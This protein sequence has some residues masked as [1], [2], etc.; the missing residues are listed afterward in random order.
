MQSV[1]VTRRVTAVVALLAP[2]A[3]VTLAVVM[4]VARPL[5]VAGAVLG[6]VVGLYSA[7]YALTRT[8]F[9]RA[10]AALLAVLALASPVA[11]ILVFGSVWDFI[12]ILGVGAAGAAAARH[13]LGRDI[14]S[15]KRGPTPGEPVGPAQRPVLLMNPRS[16]GGKVERF[17]LVEEARRRGIEPV[18]LGPG[19]DLAELA[20][21]AVANGADAIGM[22]G[23][24]GS[25][26]L[27]AEVAMRHGVG[28]VC[29]PAGTRNHL[30]MDLGLDRNDVVGALDA[31]GD[32]V[33]RRIDLAMS[34]D[35]VFVNNACM[36]L[37]AK[38]VQSPAYRQRKVATALEMLP[39]LLGTPSP[40]FDL[41][42]TGPD[43]R[44]HSSAHL[45]LVSN[46]RYELTRVEG[47]GSRRRI[48]AGV[49]GIVTATFRS[50]ADVALFIELQALGLARRFP[51]WME[52]TDTSFEVRS[53]KSV[54]IGVDGDPISQE[55]AIPFRIV[56]KALRVRI[57]HHAP[58]YSPAAAVPTRGWSTFVALWQTA[59]GR[60]VSVD[61]RD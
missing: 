20:R 6:L 51:G 37:Y 35:A 58:G 8:G 45:L 22:A 26:A 39:G 49:L 17:A 7:A 3:L 21:T 56:P 19:D 34:G 52:W 59:A 23:G 15:L 25:Q 4:L 9:R 40:P 31:F 27:V 50:P 32:A 30:A 48:D 33:E 28:Y 57:P 18:V 60:P 53:A 43:G 46:G 54:E 38:I 44:E 2:V 11:L 24:D 29:V 14:K 61:P 5:V 1:A 42:F 12:A 13:A 41:R 47:F 36:G 55:P 16:G 10:V